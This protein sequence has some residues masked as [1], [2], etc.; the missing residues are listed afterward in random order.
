MGI[1][2]SEDQVIQGI[3]ILISKDDLTDVWDE[4]QVDDDKNESKSDW[5]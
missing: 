3:K 4:E 5:N 2:D 1:R